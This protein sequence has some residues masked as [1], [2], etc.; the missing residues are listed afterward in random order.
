[1]KA[2]PPVTNPHPLFAYSSRHWWVG[3]LSGILFLIVGV[4]VMLTP[5]ESF[6]VLATL[7]AVMFLI[8]GVIEIVTAIL[9]RKVAHAWGWRL[10][11]GIFD[12]VIGIILVANP[13]LNFAVLPF[14]VGF[15]VLFRSVMAIGDSIKM[16]GYAIGSWGWLLALGII[17]L[18]FSFI[19]LRNP[20]LAGMTV[21]VWTSLAFSTI[22]VF[23]IWFAFALRALGKAGQTSDVNLQD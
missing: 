20:I 10:A 13:M 2:E 8:N 11:G 3:L 15:G 23:S 9:E 19:L 17:G 6:L 21:V 16:R 5:L 12:L 22:G 18:L 4:W 7:F 1:M 14:I